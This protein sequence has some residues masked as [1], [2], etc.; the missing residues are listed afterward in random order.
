MWGQATVI[1]VLSLFGV[2][3]GASLQ[4]YFGRTLEGRKQ[5]A[6]QRS[7]AYVD[8]FKVVALIA[9]HGPSKDSLALAADAKV[10]VCI[11][12]SPLVIKQL[13]AFEATGAAIKSAGSAAI[14]MDLLRAMRADTGMSDRGISQQDFHNIVL[15]PKFGSSN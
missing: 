3:I 7:Q 14:I 6:L 11:Y 9:Q 1:A 8:Y 2:M 5:L 4:Y 15:G 10:R 13:S 12:G